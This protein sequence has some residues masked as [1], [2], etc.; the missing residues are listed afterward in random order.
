MEMLASYASELL[1]SWGY[2]GI[3]AGLVVLWLVF[4]VCMEILYARARKPLNGLTGVGELPAEQGE[5]T[6][7]GGKH[8]A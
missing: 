3:A 6:R 8:A 5:T 7:T 4:F 2:W 1:M